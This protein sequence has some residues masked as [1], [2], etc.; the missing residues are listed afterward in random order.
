[1][2]DRFKRLF[3]GSP[4]RTALLLFV[5]SL[6]VR[7]AV[8]APVVAARVQPRGDEFEYLRRASA[9]QHLLKE[10]PGC[11]FSRGTFN[12]EAVSHAYSSGQHPPLHPLLISMGFL[13]CGRSVA[14]ARL[15]VVLLSAA[16]T[17]LIYLLSRK[18]TTEKGAVAAGLLH[19]FYPSFLAFSHLVFAETTLIFFCVPCLLCA[20]SLK[21]ARTP[22]RGAIHALLT[23]VFLGLAGLSRSI[24]LLWFGVIPV[25]VALV[26][27]GARRKLAFSGLV[28]LGC[29][30]AVLPWEIALYAGEGHFVPLSSRGSGFYLY[31][32]NNPYRLR[33][34]PGKADKQAA[35][36]I[37]EYSAREGVHPSTA[38]S[39]LT[40][41]YAARH[42]G[43]FI[44]DCL[45]RAG[46]L[47]LADDF[48]LRHVHFVI[49]P[50]TSCFWAA[51]LWIVLAVGMLGLLTA[52]FIG[53]FVRGPGLSE[54]C[55]FAALVACGLLPSVLVVVNARGVV[56][57]LAIL[58]PFAGHGLTAL[59]RPLD[60]RRRV[61]LA[62]GA[63]FCL[64]CL[65]NMAWYLPRPARKSPSSHYAALF[66][67]IDSFAGSKVEIGDT[68]ILR[69]ESSRMGEALRIRVLGEGYKFCELQEGPWLQRLGPAECVWRIGEGDKEQEYAGI[70]PELPLAR[71][72]RWQRGTKE[73]ELALRAASRSAEG[74]PRFRVSL[75]SSGESAVFRPVRAANWRR[76]RRTGIAGIE[77]VWTGST[78]GT[79]ALADRAAK[80]WKVP[81]R[82]PR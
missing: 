33:M 63:M 72:E 34:A 15:V 30:L 52:I 16:S 11:V 8:W 74:P 47:L 71:S 56:F 28:V 20:L 26:V 73:T 12:E 45:R 81:A 50:P 66:R 3:I 60:R 42:P 51:L 58:L 82:P 43:H 70:R 40:L 2:R 4:R 75:G 44:V 67:A 64:L 29:V 32:G 49:Y 9:F 68:I 37:H 13:V 48:V 36:E 61:A 59:R 54:R 62:I 69:V 22:R 17:I 23:G 65:L 31:Y 24:V 7:M 57:L 18:L 53:F 1:M 78:S 35:R 79:E 5:L 46:A 6:A 10:A 77:Y 19:V 80:L 21:D 39:R 76:W 55:L 41:R 38:G 27:Q 25:W 14:A